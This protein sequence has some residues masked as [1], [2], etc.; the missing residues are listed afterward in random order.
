VKHTVAAQ[1]PA[2]RFQIPSQ[3]KIIRTALAIPP[4]KL[5][6][7]LTDAAFV[8]PHLRSEIDFLFF[9]KEQRLFALCF[10]QLVFGEN[11]V[12]RI[13]LSASNFEFAFN[14]AN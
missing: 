5:G 7:T 3:L 14:F 12:S 2:T 4:E 1:L 8:R 9:S 6:R 11:F 13:P 10:K